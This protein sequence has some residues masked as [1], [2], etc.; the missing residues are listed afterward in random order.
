MESLL[1]L[2]LVARLVWPFTFHSL[3]T[4]ARQC[5][6]LLFPNGMYYALCDFYIFRRVNPLSFFFLSSTLLSKFPLSCLDLY[7]HTKFH[8]KEIYPS[9]P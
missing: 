4:R 2:V 9:L 7:R 3:F 5:L 1:G 8:F 6:T